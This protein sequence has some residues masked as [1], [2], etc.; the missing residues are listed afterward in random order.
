MFEDPI[1]PCPLPATY[2]QGDNC[3]S[4]THFLCTEVKFVCE[5]SV[6]DDFECEDGFTCGSHGFDCLY[7]FDDSD[8]PPTT[9]FSACVV[10]RFYDEDGPG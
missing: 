10:G 8:C 7:S 9:S 1:N 6:G 2:W 4:G 3:P 5:G